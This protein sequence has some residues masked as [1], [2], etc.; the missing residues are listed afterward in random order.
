MDFTEKQVSFD[1]KFH[2][3]I[4]RVREDEVLTPTGNTAR[5]EVCEH[6]G[7]VAVLPLSA[8]GEVTLVGQYRYPYGEML[9]ELP[10]GKLD[11][12]DSEPLQCGIRELK[13]ETGLSAGRYTSL[14]KVYPSPGFL[15]EIIHLFL[16]Q[17][18]TLAAAC[19]EEDELLVLKKMPFSQVENMIATGEIV[20]AKTIVA[21]YRAKLLL[22]Q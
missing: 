14:G 7:G 18:L 5:R 9:W 2:G 19:P 8:E 17:D 16:A 4:I 22:N 1:Y 3:R 6:P 12:G 13:E 21:M 20:D 11:A 10:A 15:N